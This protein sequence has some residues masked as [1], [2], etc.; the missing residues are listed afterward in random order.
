MTLSIRAAIRAAIAAN[1]T[2][3]ADIG[4]YSTLS[5]ANC[6]IDTGL[7]IAFTAAGQIARIELAN[8]ALVTQ[9]YARIRLSIILA[10][11]VPG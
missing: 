9:S 6:W 1:F 5:L 4:T 3:C 11:G 8:Y 7:S 2:R 10:P